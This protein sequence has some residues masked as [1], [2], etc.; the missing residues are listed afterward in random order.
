MDDLFPTLIPAN[1]FIHNQNNYKQQANM[2]T[3]AGTHK[4]CN[5]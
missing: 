5:L 4:M 1:S 2:D 3:Y